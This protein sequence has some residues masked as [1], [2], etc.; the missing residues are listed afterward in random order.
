MKKMIEQTEDFFVV[1]VSAQ[2]LPHLAGTVMVI[3]A[4]S[5]GAL[6]SRRACKEGRGGHRRGEGSARFTENDTH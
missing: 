5:G 2:S 3:C 4:A 1:F 6:P